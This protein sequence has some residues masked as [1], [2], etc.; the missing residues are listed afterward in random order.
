MYNKRNWTRQS[1]RLRKK[2]REKEGKRLYTK[3]NQKYFLSTRMSLTPE[4]RA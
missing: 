4:P 1:R 3:E 2:M